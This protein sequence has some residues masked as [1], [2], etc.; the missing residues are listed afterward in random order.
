M[1]KEQ[2]FE[3]YPVWIVF[4]SNLLTIA[5]Y[6]IG[7]LIIY[8]IG[9]IWLILYLIFIIFLEYRVIHGHCVNCYYYGKTCSFGK[10]KIAS[11]FFKKGDN[12][13]FCKKITWIDILP[14]FLVSIIPIIVGIVLLIIKFNWLI[15]ILIILL[16]ILTFSGNAFVRGNIACK[17]CK[18]RELGCPA[19]QLFNKKKKL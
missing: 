10:G 11:L 1:E 3:K 14:D 13:K 4:V 9:L 12:K 16:A 17:Y 2:C 8:N 18:Q 7:A 6:V 19:E 15:L 5:I